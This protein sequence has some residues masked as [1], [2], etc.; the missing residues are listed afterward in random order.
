M[1]NAITARKANTVKTTGEGTK[2][3][4]ERIV[5]TTSEFE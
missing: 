4:D 2:E 1:L 5:M 3:D